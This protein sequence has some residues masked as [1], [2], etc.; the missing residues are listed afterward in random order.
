MRQGWSNRRL[1]PCAPNCTDGLPAATGAGSNL[2][3]HSTSL[4]ARQSVR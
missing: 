1:L 4:W 3:A 2:G